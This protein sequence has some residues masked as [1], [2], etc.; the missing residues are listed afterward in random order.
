[1]FMEF[2]YELNRAWVYGEDDDE[3]IGETNF[4]VNAGFLKGVYDAEFKER[5]STFEIFLDAYVP[6]EDGQRVYELASSS[7]NLKEDLGIV[8]Y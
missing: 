3:P 2:E 1:M 8:M 5:Y 6:E 4:V 7:G